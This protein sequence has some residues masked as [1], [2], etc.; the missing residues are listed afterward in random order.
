MIRLTINVNNVK[1]NDSILFYNYCCKKLN[2]F[3]QQLFNNID[4]TKFNIR[5]NYLIDNNILVFD[6]S[7]L[8]SNHI[9]QLIINSFK[10]Y[11]SINTQNCVVISYNIPDYILIP[12][13]NLSITHFIRYIEYGNEDLPPYKWIYNVWN[14]FN[15]H[16]QEDWERYSKLQK[17]IEGIKK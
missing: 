2:D 12:N 3:K 7:P 9:V 14:K 16:I 11:K 5:Y 1:V 6:K 13:S 10:V 17:K 8:T 4:Y 15:R